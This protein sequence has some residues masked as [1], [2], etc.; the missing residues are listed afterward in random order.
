MA[1]GKLFRV[2]RA[3]LLPALDAV[4]EAVDHKSGIPILANVL[5]RPKKGQLLLR[6]TDLTIEVETS[7]DLADDNGTAAI[8]VNGT[9]LREI[10]RNLPEAADIIFAA[11]AFPDQVRILAGR[12]KFSLL[13]LPERDFPSIADK[14]SG[15]PNEIDIA[16]LL[17]GFS[18][19]IYA[20]REDRTRPFLSGPYLHPDSGKIAIVG[21][22]GHNLAVVRVAMEQPFQFPGVIL[23]LKT[24]KAVSKIFGDRKGK[25]AL[26]VTD[27]M[28]RFSC[29]GVTL[30]SKLI[31]GTYPGYNQIIPKEQVT[32]AISSVAA[33]KGASARV[34]LVAKD[35]EKDSVFLQ[36]ERGLIK[37]AMNAGDGEAS[38]EEIAV[39]YDGE[40]IRIGFSG[41]YIRALLGSV[42]TQDVELHFFAPDRA[43]MFRP[44]IDV[45]ETYILM[46]RFK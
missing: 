28:I 8:T 24:V 11:G 9:A 25:A 38:E 1:E 41:K 22:D 29:G 33:L 4:F 39:D 23:P 26:T 18:K 10:V 5:L 27:A 20:I 17:D 46:P 34:C 31:D 3:E 16:P 19:V 14:M 6:G 37:L 30:V 21:C 7:C 32:K 45:D 35:L 44:T 12:S 40:P 42:S 13:T 43:A 15:E 36:M 2:H